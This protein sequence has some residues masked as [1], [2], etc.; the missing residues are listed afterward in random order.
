MAEYNSLLG[1]LASR[2]TFDNQLPYSWSRGSSNNQ[3]D[4]APIGGM[5]I[6]GSTGPMSTSQEWLANLSAAGKLDQL[7]P[8][9]ADEAEQEWW[10]DPKVRQLLLG[11]LGGLAGGLG[12]WKA[13][14]QMAAERNLARGVADRASAR[15]NTAPVRKAE[16][17]PVPT[18]EEEIE[19]YGRDKDAGII[20][21]LR[22]LGKLP[23]ER[24]FADWVP[25]TQTTDDRGAWQR[26]VDTHRGQLDK[27]AVGGLSRYVQGG[28]A[29]QADKIP[30][31]LSDGEFVMDADTVSALGDGN[32][33][34]GASALEQM[35]QSIRAHKRKAPINKIPPKAKKPEAYLKKGVK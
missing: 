19:F 5:S 9:A 29:G 7:E 15:W 4:G 31:L 6:P 8:A 16:G 13:G 18:P 34:A 23:S 35:R 14:K 33:A 20:D 26:A 27:Y 30:A 12:A 17:G 25:P 1:N 22:H 10:N 24:A 3:F 2:P 21:F 11:G 28:T 32:N